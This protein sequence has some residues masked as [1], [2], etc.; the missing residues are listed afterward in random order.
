MKSSHR[1]S[2]S[3]F[4]TVLHVLLTPLNK[5]ESEHGFGSSLPSVTARKHVSVP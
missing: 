5:I 3:P 4:H 2:G 1:Q